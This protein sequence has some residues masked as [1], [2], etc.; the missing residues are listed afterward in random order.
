MREDS[1]RWE[2]I[3]PSAFAHEQD[4]LRDLASYL[5]DS[6]PFHV[7]ANVEFVGTDGSINEVD[8]LVLTPSGLFVLELKHWQG[9]VG[10]DGAQWVRRMPTGRLTPEDNPYILANR[11]AKRLASLI[12]YYA[13][14]QGR[15]QHTESVFVGAAVFLHAR[16]MAARLDE[17]G[18]QHVYGLEDGGSGLDSLK[19]FLLARPRRPE[20]LV[21]PDRGRQI[22]DLVKGAKI[23]PSVAHRRVGQLILHPR[24]F[25][26]GVGWQD[27]LAGHT[28]NKTVL[29][30]VRF[31]LTSRAPAENVPVIK[32]AAEREFRL[33]QGI[34]H[35][36]IA[37]ALDLVEHA[38]GSAIVFDHAEGST[39]L[40]HWLVER[41][42]KLTLAQKLSVV[43]DLAEIVDYAHSRRLSHR[44]LHPR[45]V[46]VTEPKR[47]RPALTVTD[48]QAGGRLAGATQVSQLSSASDGAGLEIFFDDEVR[49]Y[50]APEATTSA[51]VPGSQLDVFAL[52]TI[53]Y[54][55]VAG[56]PAATSAEELVSAVRSRGLNLDAV[57]DGIPHTLVKLIYD[58]THGD[59]AKRLSTVADFRRGLEAVWEELTTPEPEP[60]TDPLEAKKND[61]LDGGLTVVRRLGTGATATALLVTRQEGEVKRELVLKVA[62]DEQH[63][64]RLAAE[65]AT[66]GG[67]KDSKVAALVEGPV[68]V[69]GRTCLLLESAGARTLAE[70]LQGGRLV[71]DLVERYGR[72]LLDIVA[73]LDGEG[74]WHRDLK[75]AN[76][77]ARPRPRDKQLRLCAFDFSMASTAATQLSAG[78][79]P[80]LDPFLGPP[81]RLRF[82]AAAERYAAA[83]TLYEMATGTL[84]R[85]GD[86]ANPSAITAEVTLDPATFDPSIAGR[87]TD[88]FGKALARD[89]GGRFDTIEEMADAWRSIFKD[90][91]PSTLQPVGPFT[92]MLTVDSPLELANLTARARSA[93]E[94][95]GV[96]T[97]GE[98]L[99]YE[100]SALTRA[101]G[102]PDATRK[103]ILAQ[104]RELRSALG[105]TAAEP[106]V[107]DRPLAHGVEAV[108]ATLLPET[109]TRNAK[110][111]TAMRVLLGYVST[112]DGSFLR[113][114]AQSDVARATGQAQPQ[115]SSWLRKYAKQ[116]LD[117]SALT[118][119][120]DEVVALLDGRGAVMSASELAEALMAARGSYTGEPARLPQA[121]GL[122]RA[123]VE[124]ELAR[125]GDARVAIRRQRGSETVL[126]GREPDDPAAETT[127]ADLLDHAAVLGQRAGRLATMDP[128][129]VRQRTIDDLR[130]VVPPAGMPAL[131]DQRLLQLAVAA[132]NDEAA[133]STQGQ[134]Y[135]VGL[136]AERALRQLAGG[137]VGQTLGVDLLRSRVSSRFP[138]AELL[139]GRPALSD[140][141]DACGLALTWDSTQQVYAPPTWQSAATSTRMASSL[142]PLTAPGAVAEV[143]TK[144]KATIEGRGYLA[145]LAPL[146]RLDPARRAL[147]ARHHLTEVDITAIMLDRLRALDFPW[148]VILAADNGSA[149]D[150]DYRGLIEL[151][152]HQVVPAIADALTI[153]APVLITEAAPLARYGQLR[154]LQELA[155]ATR[156][157][158]AARLLLLPS[159]RPEP[160]MLDQ[161]QVPL[162]SPSRQSLWLP[163]AWIDL[164]DE[165]STHR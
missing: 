47:S 6:D 63:A 91:P 95:L 33:L 101:K 103:E 69:G 126:V 4:G 148:E 12:K 26:E 159:R 110:E 130:T 81:R 13:R 155:D 25:A 120:R 97:V 45:A 70:E 94:R 71:L 116:W 129:P 113:W 92:T 149:A 142:V 8:A 127:A 160:A 49:C 56:V 20:W 38:W 154:L 64:E 10:G 136:S 144:L 59:P 109:N 11:K 140:L 157:R 19:G 54:R 131:S 146:N 27:F 125:G 73:F 3:N 68:I 39:R 105:T 135:P 85:W 2:Q 78:T 132:S 57:V 22:V 35:P 108:F 9:E 30:R 156:P 104:A 52:G 42:R 74:V 114:P 5:P 107:D 77:A 16:N 28:M 87:L 119:V 31:Y 106:V 7:W 29:R 82:D 62:R 165:R 50:Q 147:I 138:R 72:D 93:L 34:R 121:I 163:Q 44:A 134:L 158:P 152:Q 55:I 61:M 53:A 137:L 124:T 117:N 1:P 83:V 164:T 111:I 48:W 96:H 17:I 66:L 141:I 14:Q 51:D 40:D 80:Y 100:P 89:A 21:G 162:T 151:V 118:Q 43:Q 128:L 84:P 46:F 32:R 60:V 133:L 153:E 58:A 76:L 115:I 143:D 18:R 102:V 122:V 161:S 15:Q 98:L 65:A 145:V 112:P 88:F 67:L 24:P 99:G 75:P 90:I 86:N 150:A 37:Q 79:P 139:P 41:E 23:R 36:G 123:A